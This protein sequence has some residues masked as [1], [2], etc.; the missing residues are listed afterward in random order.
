M[1]DA[2]YFLGRETVASGKVPGMHF[3]REQ[4]FVLLNR[5]AASASRFFKLPERAGLRGRHT[6]RD[7]TGFTTRSEWATV[8]GPRRAARHASP[9]V[10]GRTDEPSHTSRRRHWPSPWSH[11]PSPGRSWHSPVAGR[12]RRTTRRSRVSRPQ[13]YGGV[14]HQQAERTVDRGEPGRN[15][16]PHRR[17]ERRAA[18][19]GVRAR[20]GARRHAIVRLLV[21]PRGRHLGVYTAMTAGPRGRTVACSTTRRG[22]GGRHLRR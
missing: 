7:L 6:R 8:S 15:P 10:G 18:P 2:S 21:L 14:P 13:T 17:L 1:S 3:L 16:L 4:L 12:R 5:G 20:P 19:A 11:S 22:K 9:E